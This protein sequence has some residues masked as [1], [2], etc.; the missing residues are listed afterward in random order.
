MLAMILMERWEVEV[1]TGN[2]VPHIVFPFLS[3]T[4]PSAQRQWYEVQNRARSPEQHVKMS[5]FNSFE[6]YATQKD[7]A[8]S[9]YTQSKVL[10]YNVG[11]LSVQSGRSTLPHSTSF[12]GACGNDI[13]C[14]ICQVDLEAHRGVVSSW[15]RLWDLTPKKGDVAHLPNWCG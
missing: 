5:S 2:Y 15:R 3:M 10:P 14:W 7:I 12:E 6:R 11:S 1:Y 4:L 9:H 13:R 8:A